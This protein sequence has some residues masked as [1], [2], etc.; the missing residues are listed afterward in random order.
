MFSKHHIFITILTYKVVK[1]GISSWTSADNRLSASVR[2]INHLPYDICRTIVSD[3]HTEQI[4]L[5]RTIRYRTNIAITCIFLSPRIK[6]SA[7]ALAKV[8]K[9]PLG[10][11]SHNTQRPC[12]DAITVFDFCGTIDYQGIEPWIFVYRGIVH[13][14]LPLCYQPVRCGLWIGTHYLFYKIRTCCN[15]FAK[16][17]IGGKHLQLNPKTHRALWRLLTAFR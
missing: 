7:V 5:Q 3:A 12:Y 14:A 15:S 6:F 10:G 16:H 9:P 8:C 2:L 4:Y 17:R 1:Q 13:N 11:I